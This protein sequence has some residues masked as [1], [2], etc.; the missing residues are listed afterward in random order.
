MRYR[1]KRLAVAIF[2]SLLFVKLVDNSIERVIERLISTFLP[3]EALNT[4]PR[5]ARENTLNEV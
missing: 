2:T 4:P 5:S 1:E 3:I